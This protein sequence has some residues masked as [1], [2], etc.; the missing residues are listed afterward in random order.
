MA[1]RPEVIAVLG[2]AVRT[3]RGTAGLVIAGLVILVAVIGPAVAPYSTTEFVTAPFPGPRAP[4]GSAVT[5]SAG[6]C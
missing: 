1:R 2:R 4:P 5:S 3:P 6:T